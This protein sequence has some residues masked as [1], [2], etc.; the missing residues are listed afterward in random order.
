MD[1]END[2]IIIGGGA[3]GLVA[4]VKAAERRRKVLLIEKSDRPGRKILA[5]GNGRCNMMNSGSLRY[6]G[7]REFAYKVIEKCSQYDI[8]SFFHQY[9]LYTAEE[10]EGRI[11]P[12]TYQSASVVSVLRNALKLSGAHILINN[13]VTSAVN[14]HEGFTV[15]TASGKKY[16]SDKLIIA[17][18]GAAQPRL[19]GTEDGYRFLSDMGHHLIPVHPSLVPLTTDTKSIS[20]LSGIR[21]RCGVSVK[22]DGKTIHQEAGEVLFT[23]YG[24]SGICIM[25]CA[26]YIESTGCLIELNLLQ[27]AFKNRLQASEEMRRRKEQFPDADPQWLLNGILPE[28]LSYAVL[29]QSGIK[30]Q[31]ETISDIDKSAINLIVQTASAYRIKV[32]G[33]RGI[34]NAQVTAGGIDC[35][36]FDPETMSSYLVRGLYAAGEVLN[37]DGDC[38]GYNLMFAFASGLIAGSDV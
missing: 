7:D 8:A 9:G 17:C 36:D 19:G 23:D 13:A 26:R 25:Q 1:R 33:N 20:G 37:V 11:Y 4:A 38:G 18:G 22:S 14:H 34:E 30:L 5:S 12:L 28:K 31:G 24:I 21:I 3:A 16:L 27:N 6:F 35:R 29:K 15:T 32:T 10:S 2:V